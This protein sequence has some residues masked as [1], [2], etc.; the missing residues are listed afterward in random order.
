MYET[1][2][3]KKFCHG[4]QKDSYY[5]VPEFEENMLDDVFQILL[6]GVLCR[7]KILMIFIL[8]KKV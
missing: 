3:I 6:K 8:F 4:S 1:V 5:H 7:V 2:P